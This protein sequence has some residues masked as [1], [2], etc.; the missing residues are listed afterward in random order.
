[1]A[2]ALQLAGRKSVLTRAAWHDRLEGA[3]RVKPRRQDVYHL[4]VKQSPHSDQTVLRT[5]ETRSYCLGCSLGPRKEK[6][7]TN[8]FQ[9]LRRAKFVPA[10]RGRREQKQSYWA[11]SVLED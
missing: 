1:M 7:R 11:A 2:R 5:R 6:G 8:V 4:C 10:P 3:G 9:L